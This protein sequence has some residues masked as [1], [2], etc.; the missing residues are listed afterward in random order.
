MLELCTAEQNDCL[1]K[2]I[3]TSLQC[4]R[5]GLGRTVLSRILKSTS[6]VSRIV[7]IS[8]DHLATNY[9]TF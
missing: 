8:F 3:V 2:L 5:D 4:T 7:H 1:I 6:D 9:N